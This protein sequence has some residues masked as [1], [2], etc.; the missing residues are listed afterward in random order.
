MRRLE[1]AWRSGRQGGSGLTVLA[2]DRE[3]RGAGY[4]G[5]AFT[6][7]T[8]VGVVARGD[9]DLGGP[10]IAARVAPDFFF[11]VV[12]VTKPIL[13]LSVTYN[14]DQLYYNDL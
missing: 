14:V 7:A 10:V 4:S 3:N 13:Y 1:A 11:V 8:P 5:E 6:P 9:A 2:D 12:V